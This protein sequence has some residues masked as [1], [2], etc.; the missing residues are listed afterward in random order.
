MY[1]LCLL[2]TLVPSNST[3]NIAILKLC[4]TFYIRL[5]PRFTISDIL[6]YRVSMDINLETI[7]F[8]ADLQYILMTNH[9]SDV[10]GT[11]VHL[12]KSLFEL[13]IGRMIISPKIQ[14]HTYA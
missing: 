9:S 13:N 11:Y 7:T 12:L 10:I 2:N 4:V 14:L 3:I 1:N 5:Q 8:G 6:T